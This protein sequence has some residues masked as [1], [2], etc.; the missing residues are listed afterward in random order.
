MVFFLCCFMK[1]SITMRDDFLN[2]FNSSLR[3]EIIQFAKR[4][5]E[6]SKEK[7]TVMI[8]MARKAVCL[9]DSLSTLNL[10]IFHCPVVSERILEMN[11]SW[12]KSKKIIL[13]DDALIS[14]STLYRTYQ[15]LL[16][17]GIEPEN[18]K[19]IVLCVNKKWWSQ[20]LV[21]PEPPYLELE[22]N[23]TASFCARIVE[24]ISLLPRPYSVDY[25]LYQNLRIP[26]TQIPILFSIPEWT[27]DDVSSSLQRHHNVFFNYIY[28]SKKCPDGIR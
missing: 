20:E 23:E 1:G 19:I 24:G 25:P 28:S 12:L 14:G 22:D 10:T 13:V 7:N 4:L 8:F 26:E 18:I 27:I 17:I 21:K 16:K 6:L 11:A 2:R 9:A 3:T 15:K 5:T